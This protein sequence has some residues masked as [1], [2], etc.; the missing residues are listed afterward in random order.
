M[1]DFV[2]NRVLNLQMK[3]WVLI[4]YSIY[5]KKV[6]YAQEIALHEGNILS[7]PQAI[8]EDFTAFFIRHLEDFLSRDQKRQLIRSMV[9]HYLKEKADC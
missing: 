7:M 5:D 9:H 3:L 4:Y 6:K 1:A 8:R 2:F